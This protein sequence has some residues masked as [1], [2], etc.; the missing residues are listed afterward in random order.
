MSGKTT[1]LP[2]F[3]ERPCRCG[4][5]PFPHRRFSGHCDGDDLRASYE[6]EAHE[7]ALSQYKAKRE[8]AQGEEE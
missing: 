2:R 4:A 6:R 1:S 7:C 3:P 8:Y 5:Y